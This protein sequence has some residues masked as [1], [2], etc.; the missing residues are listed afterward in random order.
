MP[1]RSSSNSASSLS[2]HKKLRVYNLPDACVLEVN[3]LYLKWYFL[4]EVEGE[5]VGH[6][7]SGCGVSYLKKKTCRVLRLQLCI[8]R[9]R[10]CNSEVMLVFLGL[11]LLHICGSWC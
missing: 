2:N 7:L 9:F 4:L 11:L 10:E 8:L 1:L 5:I 3:E 6:R